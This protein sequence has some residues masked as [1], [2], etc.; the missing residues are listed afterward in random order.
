M[1][2]KRDFLTIEETAK[3]LD[4]SKHTVGRFIQHRKL[5]ALKVN[6]RILFHITEIERFITEKKD[7]KNK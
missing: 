1:N 6:K 5:N 7:Q 4:A 3:I 2:T